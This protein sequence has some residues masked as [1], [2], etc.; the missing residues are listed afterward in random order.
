MSGGWAVTGRRGSRGIT[1]SALRGRIGTR[2]PSLASALTARGPQATNYRNKVSRRLS[3]I[4]EKW[5]YQPEH[6]DGKFADAETG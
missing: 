6:S 5:A 1:R 4:K 2:P 3:L